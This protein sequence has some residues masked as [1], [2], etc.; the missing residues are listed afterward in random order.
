MSTPADATPRTAA[1]LIE[2]GPRLPA[3]TGERFTGYGV[4][5]IAFTSGHVLALRRMAASSV[6]PA[7]TSVWHRPPGGAW[8]FFADTDPDQACGRYFGVVGRVGRDDGIRLTWRGP[9]SLSVVVPTAGLAW[10]IHLAAAPGT[11]VMTTLRR[12]LPA[13]VRR[14]PAVQTGMAMAGARMLGLR[15]LTAT[16]TTPSG[17]WFRLDAHRFWRVDASSARLRGDHLGSPTPM[18]GPTDLGDFR[19]PARGVFTMGD[20]FFEAAVPKY[21]H[22]RSTTPPAPPPAVPGAQAGGESALERLRRSV[23]EALRGPEFRTV[24]EIPRTWPVLRAH[25]FGVVDMLLEEGLIERNTNPGH[26]DARPAYRATAA[27]RRELAAAPAP[28]NG[29]EVRDHG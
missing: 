8:T 13:S 19:I 9:T 28:R 21:E 6:G 14:R 15:E 27:G 16:G 3:G 5:G 22:P 26:A 10:A 1:A 24:H 4:L 23:L 20:A 11:R 29:I 18:R 25:V 2:S 17:H 7:F 12:R